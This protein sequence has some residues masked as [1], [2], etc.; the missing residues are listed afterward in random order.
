MHIFS[1]VEPQNRSSIA[2][3]NIR[4]ENVAQLR[5]DGN[6]DGNDGCRQRPDAAVNSHLLSQI[7]PEL[8]IR[9]T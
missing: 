3:R 6:H 5:S 1:V 2:C 7:R 8:G 4:A 9:Y